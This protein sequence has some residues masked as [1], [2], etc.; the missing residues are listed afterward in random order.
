MTEPLDVGRGSPAPSSTGA[1]PLLEATGLRRSYAARGGQVQALRGVDL[2]VEEG[3]LVGLVGESG[4]GK[5]TLARCLLGLEPLD[6]GSVRLDG[7]ELSALSRREVARHVQL[8]F[9]D[10]LSSLDPR[11]RVQSIV[12]EPLHIQGELGAAERQ[13]RVAE[14]LAGV[15]LPDDAGSRYPHEFSG[16][17]RQRIGLAR[18]LATRPRLLLADEPVSSLDLSVQA[19][20]VNLLA[21]LHREHRLAL[22]LISHDLKLVLH[23]CSR[24]VVMY[25]GSVVEEGPADELAERAQHPYTRALLEAVPEPLAGPARSRRPLAGEPPSPFRP[26]SGCAFHPRCPLYAARQGKACVQQAPSL[27]PRGAV[28]VACHERS[29][30]SPS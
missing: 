18:A 2:R 22:L 23:L 12:E 16:G 4:C 19:Q 29:E 27:A 7:R 24:V 5:S 30:S 10:P 6:A 1:A 13:K 14:L 15:G 9:Q 17:Q 26:P 8:V 28:R 20:M 11:L 21:R 3:E 25:L